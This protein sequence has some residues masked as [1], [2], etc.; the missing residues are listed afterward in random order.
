[1]GST[2]EY[3][4]VVIGSG[5]GGQKAAIAAAKLGKIGRGHRARPDARRGLREHR[6][7][8]VKTLREAV[9]YLT[10]MSQRELYGASYRVKEKIT[11]ADLL[12]RTT[13]RHRQGDRRRPRSADAQPRRAVHRARAA[14]STRT[15]CWSRTPARAERITV[16]GDYIVI[17]TGTK[18]ARPAG[19]RVRRGPRAGLRRHPRPQ[20]HPHL[21]G[22]GRRGRHRH[23]VRLDVRRAGHQGHRRR[24]ARR[25]AGLLRS[26]RSSRPCSSTCATSRSRSGS[27]RRSPP[28]T[29]APRAPSRPWPA[30]SRSPPTP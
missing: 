1:M 8:P 28:S 17:A 18:P 23:R 6:H 7:H 30:A 5:P 24:E 27:A 19:C 10:G 9:V 16:S 29:S 2:Q 4:L 15:P 13:A 12:A 26:R 20:V 21:D 11:P 22:R 25:H 3:D 14:S